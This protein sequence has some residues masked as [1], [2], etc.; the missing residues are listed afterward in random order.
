LK[1]K[2]VFAFFAVM[3]LGSLAVGG[4]LTGCGT[5]DGNGDGNGDQTGVF[6]DIS[7]SEAYSLVQDHMMS[8]SFVII[9][10]R[11]AD[12]Y[13]AEHLD[14]AINIDFYASDFE[15]RLDMLDKSKVYLLYCR[16]SNRSGQAMDTMEDLGFVEVYNMTGGIQA[17]KDAGYSTVN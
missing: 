6:E 1:N 5:T 11:T 12:E 4:L 15:A 8:P 14:G 16:S 13:N 17:W 10:V 9:D 7:A 2:F 3:L